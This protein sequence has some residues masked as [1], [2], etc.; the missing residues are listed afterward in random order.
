MT[1]FHSA[2]ANKVPIEFYKK[3]IEKLQEFQDSLFQRYSF[4]HGLKKFAF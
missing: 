3:F 2:K 1:D 4:P